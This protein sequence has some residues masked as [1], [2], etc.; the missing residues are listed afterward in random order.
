MSNGVVRGTLYV[1]SAPSGAGKTSLVNALLES[2]SGI[3]VSVSHATRD[4][5]P[6][7]KS[8][9]HY[10]F[11]SIE[12]FQQRIENNDFLEHAQVFDNYYGTSKQAVEDKLQ[13]GEDVILEIDWQGARLVR[14][15]LPDCK[16]IFIL[17]PSVAALEERLRGRGQDS[18]EIIQRRMQDARS[19]AS[20][21]DE[22]DYLIIND[23]FDKAKHELGAIFVANRLNLNQQKQRHIDLLGE[24]LA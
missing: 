24:L 8:G 16:G 4:P 20:H 13:Q 21:Y 18:D 15:Q 5:R 22:Y 17:P 10:H 2:Y 19:E 3:V 1:V 6:G 9:V 12:E 23:D 11:V 7:E 14:D